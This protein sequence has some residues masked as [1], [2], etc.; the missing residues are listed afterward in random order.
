MPSLWE[1]CN[2]MDASPFFGFSTPQQTMK[3]YPGITFP[4][5]MHTHTAWL[6][7][8]V[9]V[10]LFEGLLRSHVP[11]QPIMP[12]CTLLS[13]LNH[14]RAGTKLNVSKTLLQIMTFLCR[15]CIFYFFIYV[16]GVSIE[17]ERGFIGP[18]FQEG[19]GHF[20]NTG[21]ACGF[22]LINVNAQTG[23]RT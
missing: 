8:S 11:T 20:K 17:V 18:L 15:V 14:N 21:E 9:W 16:I 1:T 6:D 7:I 13:I 5:Q 10:H 23:L 2:V 12:V 3:Q 19:T 4:I 22:N